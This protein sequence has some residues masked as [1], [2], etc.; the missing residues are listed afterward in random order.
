MGFARTHAKSVTID[1]GNKKRSPRHPNPSYPIRSSIDGLT[2]NCLWERR[3]I[4]AQNW[5][6]MNALALT[7]CCLMTCDPGSL[8]DVSHFERALRFP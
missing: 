2:D 1:H 6:G 7:I 8:N 3:E 5:P 4:G